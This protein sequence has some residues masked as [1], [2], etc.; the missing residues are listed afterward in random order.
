[1]SISVITQDIVD[2]VK[3]IPEFGGRVG[4]AVGGQE[5]DPI[6]VELHRPAVWVIYVGDDIIS[7]NEINSCFE[8]I[9]LNFVVKILVDYDNETNL[10]GTHL[11][12]L[13]KVVGAVKGNEPIYGSNWIYDG[14]GLEALEPSRMVWAQSYSI[15]IGI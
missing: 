14:Q 5:I 11:P 1:M 13:H 12:L 3:A 2:R 15:N 8:I 9:K 6:N 4:L 10:I 7:D